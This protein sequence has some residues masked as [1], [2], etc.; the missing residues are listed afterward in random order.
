M[1]GVSET[2]PLFFSWCV[3]LLGVGRT[4]F[5]HPKDG[6][7]R[8]H[9]LYNHVLCRCVRCVKCAHLCTTE[10]YT[11]GDQS[12]KAWLSSSCLESFQPQ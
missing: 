8:F 12:V 2:A 11:P 3:V 5:T 9:T 7:I 1:A 4:H 10:D 6:R